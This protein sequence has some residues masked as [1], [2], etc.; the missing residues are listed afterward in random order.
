MGRYRRWLD[1]KR[2]ISVDEPAHAVQIPYVVCSITSD[3]LLVANRIFPLT[4]HII[5]V[6]TLKSFHELEK[7]YVS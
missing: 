5:F 3:L 2:S 4:C 1:C 6:V 7:I